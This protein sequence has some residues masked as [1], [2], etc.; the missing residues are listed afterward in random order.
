LALADFMR[1]EPDYA[2]TLSA[3]YQ[4][5]RDLFCNALAQ[6]R[7]AVQP[8]AGTYFQL[9]DYS[10]ITDQPDTE[11]CELWTREYGIASIPVSVFYQDVP[12]Q[13][14]LRFCFAKT[15]E[16]LLQAAEILCKI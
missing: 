7:F 2:S 6:S 16:V 3:F 1:S 4:A 14:Y 12:Q 8:S 15:D 5:K 13:H 11:L 9:L 10:A